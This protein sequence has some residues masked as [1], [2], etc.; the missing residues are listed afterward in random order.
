MR[1]YL[2]DLSHGHG[3]PG[4]EV[5]QKIVQKVKEFDKLKIDLMDKSE[6]NIA[7]ISAF[8]VYGFAHQV[9][10][11]LLGNVPVNTVPAS[12]S[13]SSAGSDAT[14][15]ADSGSSPELKAMRGFNLGWIG[16]LKPKPSAQPRLQVTEEVAKMLTAV[17]KQIRTDQDSMP[18][19]LVSKRQETLRICKDNLERPE[20]STVPERNGGAT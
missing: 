2:I 6:D 16:R 15:H 8:S 11:V 17:D 7:K 3:Q 1:E 18:A 14:P 10:M 19:E 9:E 13:S 5:A 4:W 20:P 12:R